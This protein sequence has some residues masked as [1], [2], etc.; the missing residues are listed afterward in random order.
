MSA[1]TQQGQWW[2]PILPTLPVSVFPPG[3]VG[4]VLRTWI[5]LSLALAAAFWLQID[6]PS[7][8]AVTV[9]ILAQPLRGQ[10]LSKAFWR[11]LG[12]LAGMLASIA[13]VAAFPQERSVFLLGAGLW[14]AFCAFVGVIERNFRSYGTLLA[15]YTVALVALGSMNRPQDVFDVAFARVSCIGIGIGA[16]AVVNVVSGAP[17]AWRGLARG[18]DRMARRIRSLGRMALRGEGVPD[19]WETTGLVSEVLSLLTQISYAR[20]EIDR[21]PLRL[22][23]AQRGIVG[24]LEVIGCSHE[25]AI[26]RGAG[27]VS[28]LLLE[29][30]EKWKD[31]KTSRTSHENIMAVIWRQIRQ[32]DPDFRP[33][34]YDAYFLERASA[35]ISNNVHIFT[36][37]NTL[38]HGAPL[39]DMELREGL[40]S[41]TDL[42]SALIAGFRVF[43][44]FVLAA[45]LCVALGQ[46]DDRMGLAQTALTLVL[47]ATAVDTVKFGTGA[48]IGIPAASLV[49]SVMHFFILPHVTDMPALILVFFPLVLI[50]CLAL[51]NAKLGAIAFNFAVFLPVIIGLDNHYSMDP[52]GFVD[53]CVFYVMSAALSFIILVLLLPSK[54][55]F[56]RM[57]LVI[58]SGQDFERQRSGR[59]ELMGPELVG[60]LYDRLSMLQARSRRIMRTGSSARHVFN[61]VAGIEGFTMTIARLRYVLAQAE[62]WPRLAKSAQEARRELFE[63]KYGN[64]QDQLTRHAMIFLQLSESGEEDERVRALTCV[65][66]LQAVSEAFL[67]NHRTLTH[68]GLTVP[69]GAA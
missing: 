22:A 62:K 11:L 34:T 60:R 13:L 33:T 42:I 2:R 48:L 44:G 15:G 8:A 43:I 7:G 3:W 25:L 10:A 12:T 69:R 29:H 31:H 46:P 17:E 24:M 66:G 5:S 37:M 54:P 41:H 9:M 1:Q 55:R 63:E 64:M 56:Q 4:F 38:L 14:M 53:R 28:P 19:M 51:M 30:V 67:R 61:R 58:S 23:G 40:G 21:A 26:A 35:L 6:G 57:E 52:V 18:M 27:H 50:S 20:M 36:G 68:Y 39:R 65:A 49:A 16:V 59:G 47:A 45:L 32:E